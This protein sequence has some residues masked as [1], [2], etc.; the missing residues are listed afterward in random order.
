MIPLNKSFKNSPRS[1]CMCYKGDEVLVPGKQSKHLHPTSDQVFQIRT[2]QTKARPSINKRKKAS[3]AKRILFC[4]LLA[5]VPLLRLHLQLQSPLSWLSPTWIC[6]G[7]AAAA[8]HPL[9]NS[10]ETSH[11]FAF[12]FPREQGTLSPERHIKCQ[13][14]FVCQ[15]TVC[16]F[17]ALHGSI[18]W[19]R[20]IRKT[21]NT[22]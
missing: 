9:M 13:G 16:W 17:L 6:W 18:S 21:G 1:Q 7:V 15:F 8:W 3:E 11:R 5:C 20:S 12:L 14:K 19:R 10:Q 22:T 2:N 4:F